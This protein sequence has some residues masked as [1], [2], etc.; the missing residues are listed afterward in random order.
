MDVPLPPGAPPPLPP[1]CSS[2]CHALVSPGPV[3][4]R[5]ERRVL[6]S[7]CPM[8]QRLARRAGTAACTYAPSP[9][10]AAQ[11]LRVAVGCALPVALFFA[12]PGDTDHSTDWA[13]ATLWASVTVIMITLPMLGQAA[14]MWWQRTAGTLAGGLLAWAL[15]AAAPACRAYLA[16]MAVVLAGVGHT[17]GEHAGLA[18]FGKLFSMTS[19]LVLLAPLPP[20]PQFT[21]RRGAVQAGWLPRCNMFSFAL[22]PDQ[23][24]KR[25][26]P[27]LRCL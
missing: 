10:A 11:G 24:V 14:P 16:T 23:D 22:L 25:L 5:L 15:L 17:I 8:L 4:Q 19:M 21:V 13:D 7:R 1:G 27:S 12:Q 18:Y 3:L 6:A 20:A 2:E 26:A 9:A